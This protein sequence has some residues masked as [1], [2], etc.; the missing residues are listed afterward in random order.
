MVSGLASAPDPSKVRVTGP[1]IQDGVLQRYQSH[2]KVDTNGAGG[3][4]LTVK[5]RGPRGWKLYGYRTNFVSLIT[6]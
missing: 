4:E 5:I 3:G 6:C 1:G 2:F